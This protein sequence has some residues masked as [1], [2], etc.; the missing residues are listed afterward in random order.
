[1][2]NQC[3]GSCGGVECPSGQRCRLGTC[4]TDPC[5]KQCPFG[6]ACHD[7]TG[8]C[9]DNPCEFVTCQP[10]QY[11]NANNGGMCEPDPC[12]VF[13][14][15]CP[16]PGDVCKGGTCYDPA[17]FLPDAG[18]EERVT[19]GGGGGCNAGGDAGLLLGLA[20]LLLRRRRTG[21]RS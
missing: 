11:C 16:D 13:G 5:G 15:V 6:Q 10:G 4:E 7:E 18:K 12:K 19:T 8:E 9:V 3:Y 14:V 21:G 20:A 2:N 1:V 17:S